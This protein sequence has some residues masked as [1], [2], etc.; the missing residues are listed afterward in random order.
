MCSPTG[1]EFGMWWNGQCEVGIPKG[2]EFDCR[3]T[4]DLEVCSRGGSSAD[5]DLPSFPEIENEFWIPVTRT[6]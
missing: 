3:F 2:Y 5:E 6:A 4:G 1:A